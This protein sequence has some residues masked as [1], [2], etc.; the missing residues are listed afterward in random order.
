MYT[1]YKT[2]LEVKLF[3]ISMVISHWPSKRIMFGKQCFK[4]LFGKTMFNT[5]NRTH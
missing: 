1:M 4:I 3:I 2:G 5:L